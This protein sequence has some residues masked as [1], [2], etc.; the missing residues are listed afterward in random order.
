MSIGPRGRRPAAFERKRR[1]AYRGAFQ[2]SCPQRPAPSMQAR[3]ET[4]LRITWNR[5]HVVRGR[6][7]SHGSNEPQT[8]A[9]TA[10]LCIRKNIPATRGGARK[11]TVV[12][13]RLAKGNG[14]GAQIA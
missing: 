5:F 4:I 8:L 10:R 7:L 1:R 3:S 14:D 12:T 9:L 11:T 6:V 2:F 13:T